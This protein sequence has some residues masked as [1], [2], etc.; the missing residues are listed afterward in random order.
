LVTMVLRGDVM[1]HEK[2]LICIIYF[3]HGW[4]DLV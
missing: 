3:I 4:F 2:D 1:N